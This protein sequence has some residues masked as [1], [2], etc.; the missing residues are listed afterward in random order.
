M[1][2]TETSGKGIYQNKAAG[3]SNRLP[4]NNAIVGIHEPHGHIFFINFSSK[5]SDKKWFLM[6]GPMKKV[7]DANETIF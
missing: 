1:N 4:N 3:K 7:D 5:S 2:N 6:D